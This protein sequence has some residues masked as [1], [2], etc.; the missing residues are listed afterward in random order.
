VRAASAAHY[1]DLFD[2]EMD[3]VSDAVNTLT[4]IVAEAVLIQICPWWPAVMPWS[5]PSE[6]KR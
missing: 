4:E 2:S 3:Q 1:A 5:H 6:S